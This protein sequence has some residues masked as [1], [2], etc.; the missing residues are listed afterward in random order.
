VTLKSDFL[1]KTVSDNVLVCLAKVGVVLIAFLVFAPRALS[2]G[3]PSLCFDEGLSVFFASKPLPDL[4]DTL[5]RE[6]LHPPLHYLL[7]HFWMPFAGKSE[8][9]VRFISLFASVL[10]PPLTFAT[11][12]EVYAGDEKA[13]QASAVVGLS[14]ATLVG[15]SPFLASYSQ[16]ARMYSLVAS[17]TLATICA[18]LKASRSSGLCWWIAYGILLTLG[19][20]THY[21]ASLLVPGFLAYV[22]MSGLKSAR[23]GLSFTALAW[24]LFLPWLTPAY[25]QLNRLI[26]WPDYWV[27]TTLSLEAVLRDI[28]GALL[29]SDLRH[30]GLGLVVVFAISV[31]FMLAHSLLKGP[32]V[33]R[34]QALIL[35]VSIVPVLMIY[36]AVS[37]M[38]KFGT[39]Y[40]IIVAAPFY[41]SLTAGLYTL[42]WCR[43]ILARLLF[44]AL[45]TWAALLSFQ[46]SIDRVQGRERQRD[47][48]RSVA[49]YLN[50]HA[51]A[52]DSVLLVENA[53]YAFVYYYR[54]K[55]PWHGL[56]VGQDFQHGASELNRILK[57]R[58]RRLW[59]VLWHHEFAD[60][61]D[62]IV[63]ELMRVGREMPID[64][65]FVG[66][67]LRAFELKD[68]E[69]VVYAF[70]EP[71]RV[72]K[73]NFAD[74]LH[75]R[76]FDV[77]GWE[78]GARHYV[79]YWEATQPLKRDY[80]LTLSLSDE[81]GHEY[82]RADR[83]LSTPYFLPPAWPV[84]MPIR[85][86]VDLRL[87]K[88]LPPITYQV[89]LKVFDPV[90]QGNL[91][92]FD[93]R[94]A[95]KGKD[96]LLEQAK[97][98][99]GELSDSLSPPPK[100]LDAPLAAGLKLM[101]Y[102]ATPR[103]LGSGDRLRLALWWQAT[104]EARR[105]YQQKVRLVEA[106]G[107]VAY[108][109]ELPILLG[110][111]T[112]QWG[113][114]EV[115][116]VVQDVLLPIDL[117]A[118]RYALQVG[119]GDEFVKLT[120]LTV[121]ERQRNYVM[122]PMQRRLN[123]DFGGVVT[124]LGYDSSAEQV[125]AGQALAVTLYW[126]AQGRIETSYKVTVQALS[127][128]MRVVGQDDSLPMGWTYPT[129]AWAPG[130]VVTDAHELEI[131][132]GT[133]PGHYTLIVALYEECTGRRL[134]ST[135]AGKHADHA[136]LRSIQVMP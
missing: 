115:N 113:S 76:G 36:L 123:V 37:L 51:Q 128:E 74:L 65:E 42:L 3:E 82:L 121:V 102:S 13:K 56:H 135:Q 40:T 44:T 16:E 22:F 71:K 33:F 34:R 64:R 99:K 29:P 83:A 136:V 81:A 92:V 10:L 7:L 87:P 94:G 60:P 27:M 89:W 73:A 85:G 68:H 48:V 112:S 2:L 53:P 69:E 98:T 62:M 116:R 97:I 9:A 88:D 104:G 131:K 15:F 109:K 54:G 26:R 67:K 4:L 55:A 126:Q 90:A 11:V 100:P 108:E 132:Q 6:D 63:T 70:P 79:L 129:T 49:F 72:L 78:V 41:I 47:D 32:P 133:K 117:K 1:R 105:D 110:Y 125:R 8:F 101:G 17:L 23:R 122:P 21:S 25:L 58:P 119:L 46:A 124:L 95:A 45:V 5:V 39:R 52:D 118:G 30:L 31:S 84:G 43:P 59:L 18:L 35:L 57:A 12:R 120:K 130:E 80:S 127:K 91:D 75:L 96:V 66:Y 28:S 61:S 86:R 20:Y 114:G 111:P 103:T 93:K 107:G 19:L 38:P 50:E 14:A 134:S 106:G 77:V 24:L